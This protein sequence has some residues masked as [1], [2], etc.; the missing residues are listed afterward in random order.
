MRIVR[1]F[2]ALLVVSALAVGVVAPAASAGSSWKYRSSGKAAQS[3]WTQV[4]GTPT[5]GPFGNVHI[6]W[7]YV[8]E[9]STG[10]GDAFGFIED[11]D[12]EPG[13]LPNGGGHGEPTPGCTYVGFRWAEGYGLT[14]NMDKKLN[15]ARLQGRLTVYGGGHG[16]GGVVGTPLADVR[17]TGVGNTFTNRS[18]WRYR[19]G[20]TTYTDRSSSTDR[21]ATMSGFIGPMGFDPSLSGGFMS[22]F[23]TAS[24]GRTK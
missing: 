11:Y 21:D 16:E 23:K 20:T 12:C 4:D 6:G 9:T 19:D 17:W 2:T 13:K 18:T 22:N 5:G 14:F 3:W 8:Y 24:M 1:R 15:S 10:L 7:L